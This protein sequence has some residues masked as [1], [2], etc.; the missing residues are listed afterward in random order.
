MVQMGYRRY[1]P[2]NP[3]KP[4]RRYHGNDSIES[5]PVNIPGI[6]SRPS[7][8]VTPTILPNATKL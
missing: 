7:D 2:I 4:A 3:K 5:T 6:P 8:I 1:V